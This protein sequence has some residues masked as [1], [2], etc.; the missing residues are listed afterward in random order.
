LVKL[1]NKIIVDAC[2]QGASD[3]HVPAGQRPWACVSARDG[4]LSN[5][6]EVPIYRSRGHAPEDHVDL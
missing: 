1:V 3:I 5:Y 6:I 4:S 2:N